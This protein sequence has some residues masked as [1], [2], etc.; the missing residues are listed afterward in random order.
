MERHVYLFEWSS[1]PIPIQL[2]GLVQSEYHHHLVEC[3]NVICSHH[4][5][6][7]VEKWLR[8]CYTITRSLLNLRSPL[9]FLQIEI[10]LYYQRVC[11]V[12]NYTKKSRVPT[13]PFII[14]VYIIKAFY[15]NTVLYLTF[16]SVINSTSSTHF[17]Y[18]F[19]EAF[20]DKLINK[21]ETYWVICM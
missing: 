12:P 21:Q 20:P 10:H 6:P 15:I 11:P 18:L 7:V 17:F 14:Q 2:V 9:I 4:D 3:T 16:L 19:F 8:W 1:I 5:I 13:R